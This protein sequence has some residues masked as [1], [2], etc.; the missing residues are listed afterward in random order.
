M[1]IKIL[2]HVAPWCKKQFDA[3]ANGFS[4]NSEIR[5]VSGFKD[6]DQTDL[7]SAYNKYVTSRDFELIKDERDSE[8][9]ARCRLLRS[10]PNKV[11]YRHV[12]AMRV[13]IREMLL[14]EKPDVLIC[15]SVDQFLHD[16]LFQEAEDLGIHG[17]GLIRT[18]VNNY[19]RISTRGE[20]QKVREVDDSEVKKVLDFLCDNQY[21]PQN[22]PKLKKNL[23]FTYFR[24]YFSN[25]ARVIFFEAF[26]YLKNEPYNY[27]YWS[28][29]RTTR[30]MYA[31]IIPKFS[32]GN[33][34]WKFKLDKSQKPVIFIPLQHFPEATVD[35]WAEDVE[36]VNYPERLIEIIKFLNSDFQILIKEHPGVWGFRKPEFYKDIENSSLNVVVCPTEISGQECISACDAVLVWTGSVGFEAALRGKPVLTTCTPYY[37]SGARFKKININHD[38]DD[39]KKFIEQCKVNKITE[40]EKIQLVRYLLNGLLPGYFQNNGTY[41]ELDPNDI[42]AAN[43]VGE[44]I[45]FVHDMR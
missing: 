21:I 16:I 43:K 37:A 14:R 5:F 15:E 38:I 3:I 31:H 10:L 29:T 35:Y 2:C 19:F 42:T 44:Y 32:F 27:H 34:D 23:L 18:F 13:S 33:K 40:Q 41:N 24:I 20:M 30:E 12:S 6:L 7:V 22:L 9:I 8:V 1:K 36:M 4:E 17:Y 28:S 26:R 25:L 39:I 11:A 45:R